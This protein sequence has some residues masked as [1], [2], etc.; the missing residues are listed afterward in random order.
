[1]RFFGGL[2]RPP[3]RNTRT[4][5]V[6]SGRA[7]AGSHC[8]AVRLDDLRS[9]EA[10]EAQSREKG[11]TQSGSLV[12]PLPG[13]HAPAQLPHYSHTGRPCA[14][15]FLPCCFFLPGRPPRLPHWTRGTERPVSGLFP[16]SF[17]RLP[18]PRGAAFCPDGPWSRLALIGPPGCRGTRQRPRRRP[19]PGGTL[20]N[21]RGRRGCCYGALP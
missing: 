2:T 10:K 11:K 4:Q 8:P 18:S 6:P 12:R 20:K 5:P 21:G 3:L 14:P 19:A 17:I 16:P 7:V 1:M 15:T 13:G 9:C